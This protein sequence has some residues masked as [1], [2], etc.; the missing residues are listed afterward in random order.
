MN[1]KFAKILFVF[2]FFAISNAYCKSDSYKIQKH[3]K[4]TGQT[5]CFDDRNASKKISCKDSH[6]LK[7]D[8][9]YQKGVTPSY[10][11]DDAKEVVIDNITGLMWQDDSDAKTVTKDWDDAKAYC[12]NLTLGGYKDWRMPNIKELESITYREKVKPAIY[13]VFLNVAPDDQYWSSSYAEYVY[14]SSMG[15]FTVYS[16]NGGVSMYKK[17]RGHYIR[18]VRNND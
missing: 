6:A 3:I 1:S 18:C 12:Q 5:V 9:Y 4:K 16:G 14:V 8:G 15:Y 13:A 10:T 11:R 7:S 2:T 17:D